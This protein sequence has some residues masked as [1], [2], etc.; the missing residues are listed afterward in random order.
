MRLAMGAQ[1]AALSKALS[2]LGAPVWSLASVAA[3][4]N[5]E[6]ARPHEALL[7]DAA[8]ER[9]LACVAAEVIREMAMGRERA[10]TVLVAADERFLA[11]VD[12]LMRLEVAL[13]REALIAALMLTN[14]WF[15]THV[16]TH[17]N[18]KTACARVFLPALFA[19][20]R[21]FTCVDELVSL[22][23]SFGD[24]TLSTANKAA[25]EGPFSSL[26]SVKNE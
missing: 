26:L 17:M 13:F 12:P 15:F 6:S 20:E 23:V 7:A 24:E 3:H 25:L 21:F 9:P 16:C 10:T 8:G 19:D 11:I 18:L 5:F 4:M 1:I 22:E 2:T 14:E